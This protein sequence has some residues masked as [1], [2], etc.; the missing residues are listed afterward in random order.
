[1]GATFAERKL[2]TIELLTK[3]EDEQMLM[4][5]E[6]LLSETKDEDWAESLSEQE[7]AAI[8]QGL[9]DLEAGKAEDYEAFQKRM[10]RKFS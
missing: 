8:R 7:Q 10:Q 1:M 9:E 2:H 3:L 5:I 6:Q 4:L